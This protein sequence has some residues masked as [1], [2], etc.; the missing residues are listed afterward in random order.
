MSNDG[1]KQKKP[2]KVGF[3]SID[4]RLMAKQDITIHQKVLLSQVV[5]MMYSTGRYNASNDYIT[6]TTGFNKKTIGKAFKVFNERGWLHHV[7]VPGGGRW[8]YFNQEHRTNL[9]NYIGSVE[10]HKG[11][12]K[13]LKKY[14]VNEILPL[15]ELI[16]L[17]QPEGV[18]TDNTPQEVK[19]IEKAKAVQQL[20]PPSDS[21]DDEI[22]D[23]LENQGDLN[24]HTLK[25]NEVPKSE[26]GE[27]DTIEY[28]YLG[29]WWTVNR[30]IDE[31]IR[32]L[33]DHI[34]GLTPAII[35]K[36]CEGEPVD[37]DLS[38][39]DFRYKLKQTA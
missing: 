16:P 18:K 11:F 36:V 37:I 12:L 23:N 22:T 15:L 19:A 9:Q 13:S 20:L 14:E 38:G 2:K 7:T 33:K 35:K 21:A 30:P 5:S 29:T 24:R 17:T 26:F 39:F 34:K 1:S 8:V 27:P 3:T 28:C 32:N 25:R 6:A 31:E 10:E 4:N